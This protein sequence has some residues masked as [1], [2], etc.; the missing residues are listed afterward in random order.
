LTTAV[1]AT[2]R[3]GPDGFTSLTEY[4]L[5]RRHLFAYEEAVRKSTPRDCVLDIACGIGYAL[6]RLN[7]GQRCVIALDLALAPL[8]DLAGLTGVHR[9]QA[10]AAQIPLADCS[11]DL[12]L[13]FQMLEHVS[14]GVARQILRE[15]HRVLN[16]GGVAFLTTPNARW[17]LLPGQRPWNPFHVTEYSPKTISKLCEQADVGDYRIRGVVGLEGAQHR[18]LAR[19]RQDPLQVYGGRAGPVLRRVV[20]RLVKAPKLVSEAITAEHETVEWFALTD[21]FT[22]GLDFWIELRK[23][24]NPSANCPI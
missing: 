5:Y 22:Q 16:D 23:G 4:L 20:N 14:A 11:V 12:I 18:E 17:R 8:R 24:R 6:A 1:E 19:V 7:Q 13:C 2:W 21:D 10:N 15:I 9:V 3:V